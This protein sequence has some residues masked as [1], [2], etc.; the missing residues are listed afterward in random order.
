MAHQHQH[1]KGKA[2]Q[3]SKLVPHGRKPISLLDHGCFTPDNQ[4]RSLADEKILY[5]TSADQDNSALVAFNKLSGERLRVPFLHFHAPRTKQ[6]NKKRTTFPLDTLKY[7]YKSSQE[8]LRIL[9]LHFHA[10]RPKQNKP[11]RTNFPLDHLNFGYKSSPAP[12]LIEVILQVIGIDLYCPTGLAE[13]YTEV[14]L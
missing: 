8:R 4:Y 7:G 10:P 2:S 1:R 12:L 5:T 13:A 11:K 9:F 3:T 6:S 14:V